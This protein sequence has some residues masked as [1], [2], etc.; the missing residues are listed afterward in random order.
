MNGTPGAIPMGAVPLLGQQQANIAQVYQQLFL[1]MFVPMVPQLAVFRASHGYAVEGGL[2][3][4]A[5]PKR[6][7]EEAASYCEAAMERL[8]FTRTRE[9]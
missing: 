1:G 9:G 7:A 3:E 6:V 5:T 8:G 4:A 2:T